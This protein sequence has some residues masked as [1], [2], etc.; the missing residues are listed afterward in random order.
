MTTDDLHSNMANW[1]ELAS[2][3]IR[4]TAEIVKLEAENAK[5]RKALEIYAK[6]ENWQCYK[7]Q[8]RVI[9][10]YHPYEDGFKIAQ[11]ALRQDGEVKGE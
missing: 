2:D 11:A 4:H 10:N 6:P 8:E 1:D 7:R 5:F 3:Y 9:W